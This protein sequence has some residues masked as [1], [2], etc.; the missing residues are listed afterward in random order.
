MDVRE[1]KTTLNQE[2]ERRKVKRQARDAFFEYR[3]WIPKAHPPEDR[4]AL[5][6]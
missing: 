3:V 5:T 2:I 4:Y 1:A 6:K